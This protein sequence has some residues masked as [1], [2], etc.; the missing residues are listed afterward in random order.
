MANKYLEQYER[1]QRSYDRF[2]QINSRL[3]DKV[4]SDYEDDVYA[5]FMHCYHLKDWVKN[6]PW[7]KLQTPNIGADVE[8]FISDSEALRL[9]AALCSSRTRLE[10]NRSHVS[11]PSMFG[12]KRY[13]S[14]LNIG[15]RSST[16][17]EWLVQ[18]KNNKPPIDAFEL[19][20]ECIAEWN[21]F[22]QRFKSQ[23]L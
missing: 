10:L 2:R 1:M 17:L 12:R 20:T 3:A 4:S 5:F 23:I 19:A 13:H 18:Q 9:C 8:Q 11:K 22:L 16:R 14:Q 15:S 21:K 6:D 7:V